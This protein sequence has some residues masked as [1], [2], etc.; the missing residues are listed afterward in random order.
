MRVPQRATRR[1]TRSICYFFTYSSPRDSIVVPICYTCEVLRFTVRLVN[2]VETHLPFLA[3]S[4]S[5][6]IHLPPERSNHSLTLFFCHV[7][8]HYSR[9]QRPPRCV[10]LPITH[11]EC[12][13]STNCVASLIYLTARHCRGQS[14]SPRMSMVKYSTFL[15]RRQRRHLSHTQTRKMSPFS[16]GLALRLTRSVETQPRP[17]QNTHI[18][19]LT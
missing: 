19:H 6:A 14:I 7:H 16:L 18:P 8:C 9:P 5:G 12:T 3:R 17:L 1:I 2:P 13:R 11:H 10:F 4:T 15:V